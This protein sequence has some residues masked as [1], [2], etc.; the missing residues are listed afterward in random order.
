MGAGKRILQLIDYLKIS[1]NKFSTK[2]L[3]LSAST[4]IDHIING[5]NDLTSEFCGVICSAVPEINYNWLLKGEGEMLKKDVEKTTNLITD[6]DINTLAHTAI[7]YEDDLMQH[8]LFKKMVERQSLI[9]LNE[10]MPELIDRIYRM[11][12][13][14]SE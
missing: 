1:K 9:M 14:S 11:I 10:K 8:H 7:E 4:K 12:M 5:R 3:G 2:V 6:M 13:S